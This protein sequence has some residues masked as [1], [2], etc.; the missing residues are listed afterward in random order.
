[1]IKKMNRKGKE[2]VWEIIEWILIV[3]VIILVIFF[4]F[5]FDIINKIKD[6]F[7]SFGK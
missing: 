3:L 1:M 4:I 5:K 6:I 7:P 2:P